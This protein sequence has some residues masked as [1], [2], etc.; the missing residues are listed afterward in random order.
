[1]VDFLEPR[2]NLVTADRNLARRVRDHFGTRVH[3]GDYSKINDPR[4]GFTFY[5]IGRLPKAELDNV[6]NE[7]EQEDFYFCVYRV[8][9]YGTD[10]K[11]E[12]VLRL[13]MPSG[14]SMI[15]TTDPSAIEREFRSANERSKQPQKN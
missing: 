9:L 12:N 3:K 6:L 1:M 10:L 2:V 8:T 7:L 15:T 14:T 13:R 4:D 11:P 5:Y